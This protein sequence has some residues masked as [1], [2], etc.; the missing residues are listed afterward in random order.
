VI[1]GT[2]ADAVTSSATTPVAT[3]TTTHHPGGGT[4]AVINRAI[5]PASMPV[6]Q[7]HSALG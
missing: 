1:S 3:T 4:V 5:A 7:P 6:N 2:S